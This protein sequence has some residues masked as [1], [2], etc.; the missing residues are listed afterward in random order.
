MRGM[1]GRGHVISLVCS[2][3]NGLILS[4]RYH[5][6]STE[7]PGDGIICGKHLLVV[8]STLLESFLFFFFLLSA[9]SCSWMGPGLSDVIV[10]CLYNVVV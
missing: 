3:Q 6:R 1:V 8:S 10:K 2:E 9:E 4:Y 5:W 7:S